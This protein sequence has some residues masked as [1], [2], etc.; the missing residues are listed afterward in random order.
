[1][2]HSQRFTQATHTPKPTDIPTA[3]FNAVCAALAMAGFVALIVITMF[4]MADIQVD[5]YHYTPA[6]HPA[7][8]TSTGGTLLMAI[9][10]GPEAAVSGTFY[11]TLS[12]GVGR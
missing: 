4:A 10:P 8:F 9:P 1:M 11:D 3:I 5:F 2:N 12:A 7:S 6:I